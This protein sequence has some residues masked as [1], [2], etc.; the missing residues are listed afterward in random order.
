M[1]ITLLAAILPF[2]MLLHAQEV[3]D[4]T[5]SW[6]INGD[7]EKVETKKLKRPGAIDLAAGWGSPTE[8]KADLYSDMAPKESNVSAPKNLA[9]DQMALSGSNYAG[10][11]AWSYNNQE[12]RTYIQTQ[13]KQRMKKDSLYC[14]RFYT[15]LGD[16]SKYG[17]AELGVWIGTQKVVKK[18]EGSLTYN[19]TVPAAR[20]KVHKDMNSW[21][22]VCG[23]FEAKGGEHYLI[24]GNFAATEKTLNEKVKRPKGESRMQVNSAYYYIDNVEVFPIKDRSACSCEQL[25]DAE[26]EF[27]FSRKGAPNPT[28]KPAQRVDAQVFYFKRFQRL[29]DPSMDQFL[30]DMVN[31]LKADA[32][33]KVRLVGHI[34]ATEMDRTR[35]RPDL[36]E[37]GKERAEAIRDALVEAGID[38][39]R[40]TVVGKAADD[41]ADASGTEIGMSKNRRVEVELQ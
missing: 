16:L 22:G 4:T 31:D 6:V 17:V 12:A 7:F 2:S 26:S 19:I 25:K 36:A 41:P 8:K 21:Q 28:W 37:L 35:V 10:I 39:A 18:D 15:T 32:T 29:M 1:R 11:R 40:I 30:A 27:I 14:V 38:A 34:D 9:G 3:I 5:R 24:I 33:L 20:E 23:V 13:L